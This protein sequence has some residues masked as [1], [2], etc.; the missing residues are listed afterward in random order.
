M[1]DYPNRIKELR[2][3]L[4]LT[5]DEL[6][7]KFKEPKDIAIISRWERGVNK[8]TADSLLEL[9]VILGVPATEILINTNQTDKAV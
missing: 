6:G 9:A 2:K 5:Q 8:P 4:G 3:K 1:M 7:K